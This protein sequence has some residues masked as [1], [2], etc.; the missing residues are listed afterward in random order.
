MNLRVHPAVCRIPDEGDATYLAHLQNVMVFPHKHTWWSIINL[1]AEAQSPSTPGPA[2]AWYL[3]PT[4]SD[5]RGTLVSLDPHGLPVW[6][7]WN[8]GVGPWV[9]CPSGGLHAQLAFPMAWG[10]YHP[11]FLQPVRLT[12]VLL[13]SGCGWGGVRVM[14][15][16]GEEGVRGAGRMR[17]WP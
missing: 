16:T 2:L 11:A 7:S 1:R 10:S 6:W 15:G 4:S 17:R 5:I 13:G 14:L 12:P 3:G 8:W 9:P